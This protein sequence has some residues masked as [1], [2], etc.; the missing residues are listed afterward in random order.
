MSKNRTAESTHSNWVFNGTKGFCYRRSTLS[1]QCCWSVSKCVKSEVDHLKLCIN[2][3][4]GRRSVQ[5]SSA[6]N[7]KSGPG[8]VLESQTFQGLIV[9]SHQPDVCWVPGA[10]RR[11]RAHQPVNH[12]R[13]VTERSLRL[14]RWS[15]VTNTSRWS[16]RKKSAKFRH[17][18]EHR[19]A[20]CLSSY[21][22]VPVFCMRP[23]CLL[24][25]LCV[26][27]CARAPRRCSSLLNG[28]HIH[29]SPKHHFAPA[30]SS[31]K[32]PLPLTQFSTS[33][34]FINKQMQWCDPSGLAKWNAF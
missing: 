12:R 2:R 22:A 5:K 28:Y 16:S 29:L 26:F 24:L 14:E 23:I 27:A 1:V 33:D 13:V 30:L 6:V 25:N 21:S 31:S 34:M 18:H 11:T 7:Y 4:F 8:A 10:S 9:S 32:L 20:C 3:P 17:L 15:C 19:P